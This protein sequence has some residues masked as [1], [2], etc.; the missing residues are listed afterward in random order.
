ME[1]MIPSDLLTLLFWSGAGLIVLVIVMWVL[2]WV[3]GVNEI[4]N[5][6]RTIQDEL[7]I[8]RDQQVT[9][10]SSPAARPGAAKAGASETEPSPL[11][12]P[13]PEDWRLGR[14]DKK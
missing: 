4:L 2:R 3:L 6:L 8:I 7:Q 5:M 13:I 1:Q 9:G 12:I 11:D 10:K 14:Q